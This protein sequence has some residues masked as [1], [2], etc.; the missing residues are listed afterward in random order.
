VSFVFIFFESSRAR[1]KP[2]N[3]TLPLT[4]QVRDRVRDVVVGHRQDRQLRD[5]PGAPF[6]APCA[7]VD[8]REVGVPVFIFLKVSSKKGERKKGRATP[9]LQLPKNLSPKPIPPHM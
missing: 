1:K 5:R 9:K 3:K 2:N 4:R 8:G 6:D 7:L